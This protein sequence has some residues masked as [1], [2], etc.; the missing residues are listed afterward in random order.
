MC[1][2]CNIKPTIIDGSVLRVKKT[3]INLKYQF[4]QLEQL[5]NKL[6]NYLKQMINR[7]DK[8]KIYSEVVGDMY[9]NQIINEKTFDN[10]LGYGK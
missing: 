4:Q 10:I 6:I 1:N 3:N 7:K 2:F 9:N 8:E 5:F